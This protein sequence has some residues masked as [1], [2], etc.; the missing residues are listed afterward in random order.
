MT[1]YLLQVRGHYASG[2]PW[3]FGWHVDSGQ[4]LSAIGTTW[5]TAI[6]SF[7]TDGSH[8]LETLFPTTTILDTTQAI[9]L[10]ASL[11]FLQKDVFH[12]LTLAGT[13]AN[14]GSPDRDAVVMSL[15]AAT[16]G[17]GDK[18]RSRLAAPAEDHVVSGELGTTEATRVGTAGTALLAAINAD[19]STVF[20]FNRKVTIQKPV[21]LTK[22]V[23]TE[24]F[25]STKIGSLSKRVKHVVASYH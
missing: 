22:T 8:G 25:G 6:N 24:V 20:V 3:G 4:S 16:V 17:K 11:K 2:R 9:Q 18:G 21:A 14:A 12:T 7:W 13:D 1:S 10:N 15:R 5:S 19:G 23:I